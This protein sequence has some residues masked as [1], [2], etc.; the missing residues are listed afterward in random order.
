MYLSIYLS[1]Y[2]SNVCWINQQS[3]GPNRQE[4]LLSPKD[5]RDVSVEMLFHCCTNNAN[6]S[7]V[8]LRSTFSNCHVLFRL[9]TRGTRLITHTPECADD[10]VYTH[11]SSENDKIHCFMQYFQKIRFEN[12]HDVALSLHDFCDLSRQQP[13]SNCT[14][15]AQLKWYQLTLFCL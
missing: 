10:V 15:W 2:L 8:S 6:R 4:A 14:G 1:I 3:V 5:P 9:P 11:Q 13:I 12:W 7:P